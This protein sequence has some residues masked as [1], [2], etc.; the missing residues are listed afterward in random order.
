[1]LTISHIVCLYKCTHT[2]LCVCTHAWI[3]QHVH[4]HIHVFGYLFSVLTTLYHKLTV[5]QKYYTNIIW[6]ANVYRGEL[7]KSVHKNFPVSCPTTVA[8]LSTF[9]REHTTPY[10]LALRQE[11]KYIIAGIV[12]ILELAFLIKRKDKS[13][14]Q[15]Y[16]HGLNHR[17]SILISLWFKQQHKNLGNDL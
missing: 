17:R 14:L 9:P 6:L 11:P 7:F 2:I 10:P 4:A 12:I 16:L 5:W 1:M 8:V 3:C 15:N 13:E